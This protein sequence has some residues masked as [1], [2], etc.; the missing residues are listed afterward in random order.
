[1]FQVDGYLRRL[2]D[3]LSERVASTSLA[4]KIAFRRQ[5]RHMRAHL[6]HIERLASHESIRPPSTAG[7]GGPLISFVTPLHNSRPIHLDQLLASFREQRGPCCELVLTD[8][9]STDLETL[10]WISR[11]ASEESVVIVRS[12]DNLGIAA[13]TNA[14]IAAASGIWVGLVDHDDMLAPHAVARVA[15]ALA[16]HPTCKFL[17]TDELVVDEK[18]SPLDYF[19]KPAWDPVLLSG[20][21]YINHLSL[22][23]R[24]RLME[25]GG[26]RTG[27]D[28]SQ[29][30]DLLLRYTRGLIDSEVCHLP[31]PAYVWRRYDTSY[32][33]K[34][35]DRATAHARAALGEH[36]A[37]AGVPALVDPAP[38]SDLHRIRLDRQISDWPL[39][40][41]VIPNKNALPL[42]SKVISGL[43]EN[44]DYPAMEIIVVDNGTSDP[45]VLALYDRMRQ[46][47]PLFRTEIDPAP[48]NFS[49]AVNKGIAMAKGNLVLLLNNDVEVLGRDWLKEMVSCFS[50]PEVG[51]VGAKLLYPDGTVQHAGVIAGLG[52]LAGHWFVGQP[53]DFPGPMARL[54]VRQSLS[55]VTGACLMV[56]RDCLNAVGAFDEDV[57]PIAYN[58]V[59][60]CLRAVNS[61]FRVVWTPF[62]KLIHYESASRGS[63][64]T[65]A[66]AAR[67]LRDQQALRERHGTETLQ[68][69][70]FNPWYSRDRSN[71]EVV[72]LPQLPPAR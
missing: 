41:V 44:T 61:G 27:F 19:L 35:L 21:N 29:D 56:S 18:L 32:S 30:Y 69:R 13:A 20:V 1:M 36:Y 22:F 6:G 55:V 23:R 63:D 24:D 64:E 25:I 52:G 7:A 2:W 39:V 16:A 14:G 65:P 53:D 71:P 48:F 5:V 72:Y 49:R 47:H 28:G 8:D 40:S 11:H 43:I 50:Y 46:G 45:D 31:Y 70:A 68:D 57:F 60:F 59:D 9:G 62:A 10:E 33:T 15:D 51:I 38:P 67:F 34:F 17:Y 26:L 54:R 3:M 58:D 37:R 12:A 42:I 66:N 4:R